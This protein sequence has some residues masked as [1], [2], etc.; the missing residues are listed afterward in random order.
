MQEEWG[1]EMALALEKQLGEELKAK[2]LEQADF[3]R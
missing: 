3:I 2:N 1:A